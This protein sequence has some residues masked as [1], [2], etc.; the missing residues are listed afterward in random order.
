MKLSNPLLLVTTDGAIIGERAVAR[1]LGP[2][3]FKMVREVRYLEGRGLVVDFKRDQHRAESVRRWSQP[4]ALLGLEGRIE[5]FKMEGGSRMLAPVARAL[6][7]S[8][9]HER[10]REFLVDVETEV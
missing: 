3:Y 4:G 5:L 6:N 9:S 7:V 10:T 1:D 2:K 8:R